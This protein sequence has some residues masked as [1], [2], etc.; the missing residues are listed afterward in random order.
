MKK[1]SVTALLLAV[2]ICLG[3]LS[4]CGSQQAAPAAD[5]S[6]AEEAAVSA[7]EAAPEAA[8]A[9]P[10]AETSAAED[11]EPVDEEAEGWE[12]EP[13][14][15]PL[16][17]DEVTL[18]YWLIW[19]LSA[20]TKYSDINEH[21]VIDELAE[22][23]G[24][25]LNILAQS[26]AAGQ[27]NTDL[28]IASGD[29]PDLI[30]GFNYSTG[31]D[32]AI[33][34]EVVLDIKEM[35]PE[36]APDY[37]KYLIEDNQ[38][39]WKSVQ[40][41]EGSIGAFVVVG[42]E[43]DVSDGN[44]VFQ[45]M[46]DELGFKVEDLRTMADY[47]EFLTAAKSKYDMASPLYLPGDFML[48]GDALANAYGVSLKIDA[49]TGDLPW[50]VRDGEV[51]FGYLQDGFEE[52]VTLM[53]S[54][55]QK[56]LID[57]DTASH[58]TEYRN[59]DQIGLIANKEIA[60][61]NRGAGLIDLFANISGEK[62]VPAY[63]PTVNEGEQLHVGGPDDTV[64]GETGLVIT[65]GCDDVELA[66]MFCNYLYTDEFYIPSNYGVEGETYD[67]VG[68]EPQFQEWVYSTPGR[69][70]S[71]V[72]MDYQLFTQVDANVETPGMSEAALSCDPVWSSNLDN[73]WNYPDAA[74]MTIDE[75]DQYTQR[76]GDIVALCQEYTAKFI[77]GEIPLSEISN[78]QEQIR[79]TGIE[80]C[81]E[82]KQSAY[83][84]YMSRD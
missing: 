53:N 54:W 75:S 49:I 41:D 33:D 24:V 82:A 38:K 2:L 20:D 74:A 50:T 19:E 3:M 25:R 36:F 32:A 59:E 66:M 76:A 69:T 39:L 64:S 62:V 51:Q 83:D 18:D 44:M 48:D 11:A 72:M 10:E 23:T 61:F 7:A 35:I 80:D 60:V 81:I 6:A 26:Q 16:T 70:F 84:R 12:Y 67:M 78:F 14:E 65:T 27:T 45:F 42:T 58:P 34:D 57:S 22:A 17:E 47:E 5:A 30:G 8:A 29:Y 28:M 4:G 79:T 63:F 43:P 56:G 46:L 77:T 55:Y 68:G 13:I 71:S 40:T 1:H 73:E 31:M 52:Y 15:Y 21:V 37:Y 9:A